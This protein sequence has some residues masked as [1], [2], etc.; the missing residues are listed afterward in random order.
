[1]NIMTTKNWLHFLCLF[2]CSL[3]FACSDPVEVPAE[4]PKPVKHSVCKNTGLHCFTDVGS[5]PT[6]A[7]LALA[8]ARE[9]QRWDSRD[10]E[11]RDGALVLSAQGRSRCLNDCK[12]LQAV[13]GLQDSS[14]SEIIDLRTFDPAHFRVN[15]T[16]NYTRQTA[17][18]A[19]LQS[20]NPLA[21]NPHQLS[22]EKPDPKGAGDCG[23][24][25]KFKV[26]G[27]EAENLRYR[28]E[29]FG[30]LS[31]DFLAFTVRGQRVSIDPIDGD[32]AVDTTTAGGC[33]T[34]ELDRV[35]N[36]SGSL[37]GT[38]CVTVAGVNGA[39]L[40]IRGNPGY[41]G[42]KAGAIPTRP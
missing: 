41:L 3:V 17:L 23:S 19:H 32:N 26:T 18:L 9:L 38:C 24:H 33:P 36:P 20:K 37:A 10:F 40:N 13:L 1:M 12:H 28:I 31:N 8:S 16:L 25:Y 39:L 2:I 27:T 4:T 15:L 14:V 29:L 5:D 21:L 35:Y 7:A 22:G 6:H 34:Y 30:G 11:I 42:C